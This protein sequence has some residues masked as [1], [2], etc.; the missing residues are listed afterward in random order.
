MPAALAAVWHARHLLLVFDRH[1]HQW[2]LPGGWI[3]PG[4]T[5]WQAAVRELHE[6]A[7]LHLPTLTLAGYGRFHL[8]DPPHDEYAAVYTARVTTRHTTFVPNEEIS[9]IRWWDST[10]PSPNDAQIL[11]TT[12]ALQVR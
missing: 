12:L 8:A 1:R 10:T 5:P 2:E 7:G 9:A 6:E 11:D 3:D 4:E